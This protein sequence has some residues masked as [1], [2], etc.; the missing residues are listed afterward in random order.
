MSNVFRKRA[1]LGE[2][3]RL[4]KNFAILGVGDPDCDLLA[5]RESRLIFVQI[6]RDPLQ[7]DDVP[8]LV[9]AALRE[10]ENRMDLGFFFTVIIGHAEPIKR[11]GSVTVV[12]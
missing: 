12:D 10:N 9:N 8:W 5:R 4:I 7:V 2:R 6:A 3:H 11:N 1:E